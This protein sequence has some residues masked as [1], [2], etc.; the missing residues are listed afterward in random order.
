M[1]QTGDASTRVPPSD[2]YHDSL[3]SYTIPAEF[4]P[5][6]FHKK[7]AVAA[8]R[9]GNDINPEMKSSGT[10]FYIVQG[11]IQSDS[12]LDAAEKLINKSLNQALFIKLLYHISDSIRTSGINLSED[13]IHE[14]A[15]IRMF[16]IL[17]S[18]YSYAI[19]PEQR[20][21]Y[22]TIGGVPRLDQTYTVFGEVIEGMEIVDKI[23][24]VPT[25]NLDKPLTD[26]RIIKANVLK[27]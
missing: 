25:D 13:K 12:D 8:A 20:Q 10:Q 19:P 3:F 14:L 15:I 2:K 5:G 22:K 4:V 11:I 17:S 27:K 18:S 23:A 9:T 6:L 16:D 7:G 26:V 21:V 1:I 24:S